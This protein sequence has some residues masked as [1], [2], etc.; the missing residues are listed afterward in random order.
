MNK[1]D[2]TEYLC[3]LGAYQVRVADP[4]RGFEHSLPGRHP[5]ELFTEC[6]SVIVFIVPRTIWSNN[7]ALAVKSNNSKEPDLERLPLSH[8]LFHVPGWTTVSMHLLLLERIW[9][10]GSNLLRA[11]GCQVGDGYVQE[12][13]CTVEAGLGVYGRSGQVLHPELGNRFSPG[14][15][16]T[17]AEFEA[18]PKIDDFDPCHDCHRC[19]EACPAGAYQGDGPYPG[20]WSRERCQAGRKQLEAEGIYCHECFRV[21]PAAKAEDEKLIKVRKLLSIDP[22]NQGNGSREQTHNG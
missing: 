3:S 8:R 6:R 1:P 19:V 12:K 7:T 14:V 20:N 11:R 18:D 4:H 15:L 13:L 5:L 17:D 22:G 10:A 21:C 9:Y 2:L 16:L